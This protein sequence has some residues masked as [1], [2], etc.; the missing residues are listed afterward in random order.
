[1]RPHPG[2]PVSTPLAWNELTEDVDPREF[3]MEVARSG[4]PD[5]RPLRAR[6]PR[7]PAQPRTGFSRAGERE[8][9]SDRGHRR[10]RCGEETVLLAEE[11][12]GCLR[13]AKRL[14]WSAAASVSGGVMEAVAKGASEAGGVSVGILP[15]TDVAEANRWSPMRLPPGSGRAR[16]L[17]VVASSQAAIAVGG[18]GGR[19]PRSPSLGSSAG[20]SWCSASLGEHRRG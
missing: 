17:A 20:P 15:G 6:A 19:R 10:G 5:R 18:S 14:P 11:I 13:P 3:T 2:A 1:M 16:N 7:P 4:R 12:D 8:T 9:A